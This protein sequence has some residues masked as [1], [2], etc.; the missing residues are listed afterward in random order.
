[1]EKEATNAAV[2]A[3]VLLPEEALACPA[4]LE[5]ADA[6]EESFASDFPSRTLAS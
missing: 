2:A 1:M 6:S 3:E 4:P 5:V